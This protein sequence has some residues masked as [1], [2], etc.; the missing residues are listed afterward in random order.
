MDE[1]EETHVSAKPDPAETPRVVNA[2]D[3]F[4][5]QR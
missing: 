5:K 1:N 2:N 4:G 3:L